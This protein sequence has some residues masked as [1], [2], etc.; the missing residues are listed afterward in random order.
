MQKQT[1]KDINFKGKRVLLRVDFNVPLN[2]DGEITDDTRIVKALPTIKYCLDQDAKISI[3]SHLGR[4]KGGRDEKYSLVSVANHLSKLINHKVRFLSDGVNTDSSILNGDSDI[5]LLENLR[6]HKEEAENDP[7]FA[8]KLSQF[9]DIFINDAFGVVHRA[10]ASTVGITEFLPSVAGLLLGKEIEYFDKIVANPERPFMTILGGA[11]VSDKVAM[12]SNLIDRSDAVLVGGVM[13]YAFYVA[14]GIGVGDSRF[15]NEGVEFARQ[16][17]DKAKRNG[18]PLILPIDRVVTRVF[19]KGAESKVVR[20]DIPEGWLGVD[21]G[22]NTVK[23]FCNI[24]ADAKSVVWNGPLGAFEI[25]PFEKGSHGVAEFLTT[26]DATIVI[27]GGDTAAAVN[28]FGFED[29][30]SHVST[31][32]GASL[33]YLEGQVLPGVEALM[34]R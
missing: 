17:L 33:K 21:V 14:M 31:G 28:Q 19:K 23:R 13:A 3:I 25:E 12:I 1:V 15:D 29:K 34:D 16:A 7:D 11:K 30:F 9:G 5:F 10:H 18:V 26:L 6:F 2:D 27:G 4:P 24:L 20:D 22:P 32:G 8:K